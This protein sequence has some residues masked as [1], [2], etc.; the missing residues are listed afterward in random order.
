MTQ[1]I[2]KHKVEKN[3]NSPQINCVLGNIETVYYC[4]LVIMRLCYKILQ[5]NFDYIIV[6]KELKITYRTTTI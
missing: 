3:V 1:R 6:L 4:V 5:L 2:L